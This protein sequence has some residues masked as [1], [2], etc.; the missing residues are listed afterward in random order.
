M[1]VVPVAG[2]TVELLNGIPSLDNCTSTISNDRSD[3]TIIAE[4]NS[5]VQVKVMSSPIVTMSKSLLLANT[6]EDGVGTIQNF[7]H[8]MI[9]IKIFIVIFVTHFEF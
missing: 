3:S 4:F 8:S 9:I 1:K 2:D 6:R 7:M 5:K